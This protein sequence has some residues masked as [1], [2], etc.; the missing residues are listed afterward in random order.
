MGIWVTARRGSISPLEL[1]GV[2]LTLGP[3]VFTLTMLGTLALPWAPSL[4][5]TCGILM[6]L[7]VIGLLLLARRARLGHLLQP[8]GLQQSWVLAA[9]APT[10]PPA[11]NVGNRDES[12]RHDARAATATT[13][14]PQHGRAVECE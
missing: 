5:G 9:V 14:V 4:A 11:H 7:A 10:G 8:V 6:G 12:A 13:A 3:A 1:I 2:S